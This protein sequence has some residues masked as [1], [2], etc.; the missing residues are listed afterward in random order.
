M[1]L[2]PSLLSLSLS[3]SHAHAYFLLCLL[4]RN[5]NLSGYFIA[6]KIETLRKLLTTSFTPFCDTTAFIT[7]ESVYQYT[8]GNRDLFWNYYRQDF[9]FESINMRELDICLFYLCS[10]H[11]FSVYFEL[12]SAKMSIGI[13]F[14]L[15]CFIGYIFLQRNRDFYLLLYV[16]T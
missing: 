6:N 3:L 7:F 2:S 8:A 4:S 5:P 1:Y 9:F 16:R 14:G 15:F 13:L 10:L 12:L 11:I